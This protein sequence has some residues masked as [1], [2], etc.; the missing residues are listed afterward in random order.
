MQKLVLDIPSTVILRVILVLAGVY[1]LW[2]LRDI[3]LIV[4]ASIVI[5]S[6]IEPMAKSLQKLGVPRTLAVI[7]VYFAFFS[8]FLGIILFV[9]PPILNETKSLLQ[10]LPGYVEKISGQ[11]GSYGVSESFAGTVKD[12]NSLLKNIQNGDFFTA[13]ALVF[14]GIMSFVF[15]VVFSFYFAIHE[16]GIE[17]FLR[18]LTPKDK[19]KYVVGLWRRTQKKI[20]LW[21][22]GQLLLAV[23]IGVLVYLGLAILAVPYA[24]PL[25]VLAAA[26]ELIPVF[27]PI[28]SALPA[29]ALA[30]AT[31]GFSLAIFTVGLYLIIQQF[32]NQLIYPLV[33]TKV[34]GVPP[35]IS[36]LALL[37]GAKLAGVLGILLSIPIAAAVQE[38][39]D[40]LWKSKASG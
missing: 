36:I 8:T 5:A 20:G 22:Q 25:A 29:V 10:S 13:I 32:E 12:I 38:L 11:S 4:V 1:L 35:V 21:M 2:Y 6:A 34:V 24:L 28:L 26:F 40:D 7:F 17:D 39:F 16:R 15:I 18:V 14:G 9:L 3:A 30:F 33:V 37:V 31:G 19:E 23:L 27:G